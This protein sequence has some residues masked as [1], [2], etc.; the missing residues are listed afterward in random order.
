MKRKLVAVPELN[1]DRGSGHTVHKLKNS[2][3]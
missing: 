3:W 1:T 2:Y